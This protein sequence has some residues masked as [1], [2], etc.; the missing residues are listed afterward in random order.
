MNWERI[1]RGP[2]RDLFGIG[3]AISGVAQG[4]SSIAAAGI[5]ASATNHATD[6]AKQTADNS[7]AFNKNVFDT[8]QA[9]QAPWLQAG[10]TALGQLSEG[11]AA[12]GQ[13]TQKYGQTFDP[14]KFSAPTFS[15][16]GA[17]SAPTG[18]DESND[19]GYQFR[20]QQG[21]Q[22]LERSAAAKGSATG[23]SAL[24][25]AARY[26][27]DYSSNEYGNVYNRALQTYGTNYNSA[28]NNFTTDYNS[29]LNAFN[30]NA[31]TGQNAFNTNYNVWNQD[32]GNQFN[33]LAS[34]AGLGQTANG[35]LSAA[36]TAAAGNVANINGN[37]GNNLANLTTQGGNALAAGAVG[38]G[39][40]ISSGIGN[41]QNNQMLQQILNQNNSGYGT[42]PGWQTNGVG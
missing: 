18:V 1:A 3:T 21:Q 30:T 34:L 5:Q 6:L 39:N 32:Q 28:V 9:N 24:K 31:T 38:V 2:L 20:L 4:V 12:G 42:T 8:Q 33:H 26:G 11:T 17:F 40:A 10:K 27:Q 37:L 19:P 36:G 25:A 7:L 35:Q 15:A 14:G 29:K 41:Y 16:P 13:F 23:G 22:A